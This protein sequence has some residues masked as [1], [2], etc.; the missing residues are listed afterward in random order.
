MSTDTSKSADELR[1]DIEQT[2]A[3]LGD[4]AA[5]LAAKAD[6]K[7]RLK[8][9]AA[10]TSGRIKDRAGAAAA[11]AADVA[12]RLRERA[13]GAAGSERRRDVRRPLPVAAVG[14]TAGA[15][16]ALGVLTRRRRA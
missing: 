14:T 13:A 3:E 16:V 8:E 10:R 4:T 15:L 2:R 5:A 11:Q 7:A 9:S 1:E 12:G 6:V